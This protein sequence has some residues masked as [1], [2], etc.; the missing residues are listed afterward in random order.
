MLFFC[1]RYRPRAYPSIQR[2]WTVYPCFLL[3]CSTT[4]HIPFPSCTQCRR[5]NVPRKPMT[6]LHQGPNGS[7]HLL[8]PHTT[9]RRDSRAAGFCRKAEPRKAANEKDKRKHKVQ[10][11]LFKTFTTSIASGYR[12]NMDIPQ[13]LGS[14]FCS[15]G[16]IWTH[17]LPITIVPAS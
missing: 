3:S 8:F 4:Q 9:R 2:L 7:P 13:F 17:R 10:I 14:S 12:N 16:A 1:A 5:D 15:S 6:L 11:T